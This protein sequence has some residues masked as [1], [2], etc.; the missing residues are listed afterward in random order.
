MQSDSSYL[1]ITVV[2]DLTSEMTPV[3]IRAAAGK[4]I[5]RAA[6]RGERGEEIEAEF[7]AG[8]GGGLE[9]LADELEAER[10][11]HAGSPA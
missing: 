8:I 3:Q 6:E 5:E 7:L 9:R 4:V 1:M 11:A 10:D 2:G